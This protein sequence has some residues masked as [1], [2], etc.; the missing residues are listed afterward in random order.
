MDKNVTTIVLQTPG[1][2]N[3]LHRIRDFITGIATESGIDE[4]D[5]DNIEL[6]VDEA[7]TN[8][9][10]HGYDPEATDK[11]ITIRMEIDASKLVLTII[12]QGKSFD[13]RLVQSPDLNHLI[14]MKR[15]GGLGINLIKRT[16][17]TIDYRTTSDGYNELVLTKYLQ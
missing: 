1:E 15:D 8:V 12:D 9:I 14:D 10:E 17:D 3:Y 6:A 7:C 2:V 4:Q 5:I 11:S 13:P 16:M